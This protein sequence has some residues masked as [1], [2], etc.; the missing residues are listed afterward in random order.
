VAGVALGDIYLRVLRDRRGTY[1]T[2]QAWH[3]ATCMF[4]RFTWHRGAWRHPPSFCV[5][6]VALM[7]LGWRLAARLGWD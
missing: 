2:W 6:G 3:L 1:G 5:A 7:A 4:L